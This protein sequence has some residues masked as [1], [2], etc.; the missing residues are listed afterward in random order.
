VFGLPEV[1]IGILPSSGGTHRLVR[2]LGA[3]RAKELILL[4]DRVSAPEAHR[5]G[6]ITE[7]VGEGEALQ[8][9]LALAQRLAEMPQLAL[10]V[11]KRVIDSMA[12][13]AREAELEL[14]RL[15]YGLLAQTADADAAV[16]KRLSR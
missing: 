1:G 7:V 3:A 10:R 6:L 16:T 2:Q 15:A 11:T 5:I 12:A 4:R 13:G 14:E 9:A 8:R